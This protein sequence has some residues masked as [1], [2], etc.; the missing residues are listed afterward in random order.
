[1][2]GQQVGLHYNLALQALR[3]GDKALWQ[4]ELDLASTKLAA[5]AEISNDAAEKL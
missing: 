2:E 4:R 5:A 1:M 3:G